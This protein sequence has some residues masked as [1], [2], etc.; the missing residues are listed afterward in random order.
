MISAQEARK[1]TRDYSSKWTIWDTIQ[2]KNINR[3][4]KSTLKNGGNRLSVYNIRNNVAMKLQKEKG[5]RISTCGCLGM[6]WDVI[7]W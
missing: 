2:E 7:E 3:Q 5:Y 4:I 1:M 6:T